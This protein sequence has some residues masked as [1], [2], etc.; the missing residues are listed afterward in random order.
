MSASTEEAQP[1]G[2]LATLGF[3]GLGIMGRPMAHNLLRAG[4]PLVVHDRVPEPIQELVAAGAREAESPGACARAADVVITML[5]DTPDVEAVLFGP[6]GAASSLRANALVIDMS[7]IDPLSTRRFAEALAS[8]GATLVDAPVSGGQKGAIEATLS[9]MVGGPR[10]GFE[11]A[12][13]ILETLGRTVVHVGESGAGQVTK[14]CNQL[15]VASTIEAVAEALVLA[16]KAGV[17]AARVREALLGGFAGSRILELHGQRMLDRTFEPGF[18]IR[19]HWKD[20]RII[21]S[22]ASQLG[23]PIPGFEAVARALQEMADGDGGELD[24]SAL[25]IPLEEAAGVRVGGVPR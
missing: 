5:P 1:A 2:G 18:R 12:R 16:T 19:L 4:Y 25:V 10:E 7:T 24:H 20:A 3:I 22:T 13:P 21:V 8:R 17:D 6:R 15:V 11:R 9:I 23:V 14:A